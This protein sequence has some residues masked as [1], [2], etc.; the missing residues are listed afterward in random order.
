V[1]AHAKDIYLSTPQALRRKLG[2]ARFTVTCTDFNCHALRAI[3]P[4]AQVHRMYHGIDAEVFHPRRRAT[5]GDVP[6]LLSVGRLREKKGLDTLID[7]CHLLAQRGI[8]FRCEIVGYGEQREAL[9]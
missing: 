6:L 1:S 5:P 9:Q 4:Q 2:S 3:A 7:A 8:A